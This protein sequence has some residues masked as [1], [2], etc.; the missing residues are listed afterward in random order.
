MKALRALLAVLWLAFGLTATAHALPQQPGC[1][2]P[3]M[4]H[5]HGHAGDALPAGMPCCS[6]PAVMAAP[7]PLVLTV[8]TIVYVHQ[9][10]AS[11][12]EWI[13]TRIGTEPRPPK[14]L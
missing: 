8:R 6:Q 7:T 11:S 5:H 13:G 3:G 9:T 10:P 14:D 2:M 1:D 12:P 4:A